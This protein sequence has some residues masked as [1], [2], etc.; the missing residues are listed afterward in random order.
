MINLIVETG[1]NKINERIKEITIESNF[2]ITPVS[3]LFTPKNTNGW[4]IKRY[5]SSTEINNIILGENI[6]GIV[7]ADKI[8]ILNL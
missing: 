1:L 4:L 7:Y 6:A 5:N 8:E 2:T 3:P